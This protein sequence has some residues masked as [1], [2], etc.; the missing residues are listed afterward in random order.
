MRNWTVQEEYLSNTEAK[1][2]VTMKTLSD[3]SKTKPGWA[4]VRQISKD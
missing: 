2:S 4:K 1:Y 3:F